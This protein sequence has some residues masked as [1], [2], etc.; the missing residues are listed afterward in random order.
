MAAIISD[1]IKRLFL[2]QLFDEATG[3]KLGD[4]DNQFYIGVGRSQTWDPTG[5]SDAALSPLN[6]EREEREFR[7]NAQAVKAIEAYTFVVPIK[8]WTA[9]S[10]YA[11]YN[12]NVV[13]QPATSYYIRT[14]DN[15]IY[16][17]IR[18]GK[19]V[20]GNVQ[21]S[22]VKP[23]H[24]NTSL[25]IE[26]D[27][28]IWK[29]LYTISTADTNFFVTSNYMPVKIVDSASATDPYFGQKTIQ[30]A[31]IPG[32]IVGYRVVK[33]GQNYSNNDT[34]TVVG[35]GSGATARVIVS[36]GVITAVE[37]GDSANVGAVGY[38]PILTSMGSGYEQANV[39][40]TSSG[41]NDSADIVP[42]F[43]HK[44][45]LGADPREDL[46]STAMMFNIKPEGTVD[47]K[48]VTGSQDYRQVALWRNP[49]DSAGTAFT[50]TAGTVLRKLKVTSPIPSGFA[51]EDNVRMTGDS[52]ANAWIDFM[53]DSTIWYHQDDYTGF[54]PFRKTE[55]IDIGSSP[56]ASPTYT[57]TVNEH[58]I[59]PDIDRYSGDVFFVSNDAA[60][61]RT[62][63]STDDIKLVIQL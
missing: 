33:G 41:G 51:F 40:V 35:D 45:G 42:I 1:K 59:V 43:A 24:T 53:A 28:Y 38:T 8:D 13:G 60:Q 17:C 29:Y 36:S 10:Q 56:E 37:V 58:N 34:L 23:D 54:T 22:T 55:S 12:D 6:D 47:D 3:T 18:N 25:D 27:G 5:I 63:A 62:T 15:N 61:P 32:Q 14:A 31:A 49:A 50:G 2:T 26:T 21:V 9:N 7:Y 44:A 57:R 4:S 19:D 39:R 20:L 48:W 16:V 46:R 30:N 11:Q 52:N